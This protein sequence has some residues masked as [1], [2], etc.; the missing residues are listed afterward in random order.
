MSTDTFSSTD[1]VL[2]LGILFLLPLVFFVGSW[3][4]YRTLESSPVNEVTSAYRQI[5]TSVIFVKKSQQV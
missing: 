1:P 3:L 4:I 2:L 5:G